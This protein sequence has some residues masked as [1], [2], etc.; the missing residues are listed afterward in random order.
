M[1]FRQVTILFATL[2]FMMLWCR[3]DVTEDNTDP[4]P[5]EIIYPRINLIKV[6]GDLKLNER[7]AENNYTVYFHLPIAF[8]DQVPVFLK[9]N[10][11]GLL[12]YRFVRLAPPNLLGAA[13]VQQD[14]T[15]L[16]W[17]GYVLVRELK[18]PSSGLPS[19]IPFPSEDQIPVDFRRWLRSTSCV[20]VDAPLVQET[21]E[22]VRDGTNDIKGLSRAIAAYCRD[23][24]PFN[25]NHT[26]MGFSAVYALKWGNS[27]T[28]HAHAGAALFRANRIPARIIL[29]FIP[30][31]RENFDM[32]WIIDYF[33]PGHQWIKMET[34]ANLN[35]LPSRKCVAVMVCEPEYE[36]PLFYP[37]GIDSYWFSSSPDAG[38]PGWSRAHHSRDDTVGYTLRSDD[39]SQ[40]FSLARTVWNR[41]VDTR[42]IVMDDT[43]RDHLENATTAME[44]AWSALR[45]ENSDGGKQSLQDAKDHLEQIPLLPEKNIYFND[46][47]KNADGWTHGGT[48][49][50]WEWGAPAYALD[51]SFCSFSGNKCWGT[52][53]DDTYENNA[54]NWLMSPEISLHNLS[55]AY[56]NVYI[57][58][59]LDG[60]DLHYQYDDPL[61]MEITTGGDRFEPVCGHMGG[62]NDDPEIYDMGGWGFLALDLTRYVGRKIQIRFRMTSDNQDTREGVHIDDFRIFGRENPSGD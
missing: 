25:F 15:T 1:N 41:Y 56:L 39:I 43:G 50:E 13:T 52:D 51:S 29:N 9:I 4:E 22:S 62:R 33:I 36:N 53:L 20:Q 57:R 10:G 24:I 21:A 58:N 37:N 54:D 31:Y 18:D 61:W 49:D 27:C 7:P 59:S 3:C 42:G 55:C 34:T 40:L 2:F 35:Y 26:P 38:I 47:E 12:N 48:E 60:D 11:N 45:A 17:E 6:A 28:G 8:E 5:E 14:A 16:N 46:F 44:A 23:N 19:T 32:H 30:G